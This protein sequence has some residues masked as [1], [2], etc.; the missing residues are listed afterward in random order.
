MAT[1]KPDEILNAIQK[2]EK[3]VADS[4][5]KILQQKIITAFENRGW[6]LYPIGKFDAIVICNSEKAE[7]K[8]L[9]LIVKQGRAKEKLI[10]GERYC[11]LPLHAEDSDWER[12]HALM[13]I[14]CNQKRGPYFMIFQQQNHAIKPIMR[15]FVEY[16]EINPPSI[17]LIMNYKYNS[18]SPRQVDSNVFSI[19]IDKIEM[20]LKAQLQMSLRD[21][22]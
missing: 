4:I 3:F 20:V 16:I 2:V 21:V 6:A 1:K 7:E 15:Y 13:L 14:M 10:I 19:P 9:R 22:A 12:V 5:P 18:E 8:K 17:K 11:L